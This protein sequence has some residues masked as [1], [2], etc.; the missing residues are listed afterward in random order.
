MTK[1]KRPSG[2]RSSRAGVAPCVTGGNGVCQSYNPGHNVHFI[3]ARKVGESPWGWRDGLLSSLDATGSLTVE[4]ATEAGQVEAWHH[5]DLVAEL[6]VGSPVRV[7]EGWQ[8]LASSAGWLHLNISAGLGT[9]EEPAF[10]EL[11]DDQVTYGVV[12]LSTGRGVDV[13]TK[14]F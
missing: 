11:W 5:Q 7:H 13:P 8:M 9:V 3:H 2:G 10:V 12:D 1:R 14:G 6:A 4:Y